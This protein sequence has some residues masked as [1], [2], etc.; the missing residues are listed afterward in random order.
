M[1][2][3]KMTSTIMPLLRA[4]VNCCNETFCPACTPTLARSRLRSCVYVRTYVCIYVYVYICICMYKPP[5][6]LRVCQHVTKYVCLYVCERLC[7]RRRPL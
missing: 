3:R 6:I 7:L 2:G 1:V 5:D 4:S